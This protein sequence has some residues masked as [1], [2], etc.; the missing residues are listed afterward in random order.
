MSPLALPAFRNGC[1][2]R[3]TSTTAD[4]MVIGRPGA[5]A[6]TPTTSASKSGRL[7]GPED[8]RRAIASL[9]CS[10]T[11]ASCDGCP[12]RFLPRG[13][14][15]GRRDGRYGLRGRDLKA[16]LVCVPPFAWVGLLVIL[17]LLARG[18]D[19][20][21]EVVRELRLSEPVVLV[22]GLGETVGP[23]MLL[24]SVSPLKGYAKPTYAFGEMPVCAFGI[25]MF[26]EVGIVLAGAG[27][28]VHDLDF[29]TVHFDIGRGGAVGWV[30]GVGAADIGHF[31]DHV[32]KFGCSGSIALGPEGDADVLHAVSL[33]ESADLFEH[34]K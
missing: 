6:R 23:L 25:H 2:G 13:P 1:V 8:R 33:K 31:G 12:F 19:A 3:G 29:R 20:P 9:R 17:P 32:R 4:R 15:A 14:I 27:D 10:E 18:V 30:V 28:V 24:L 11:F 34:S 26:L 21:H 22:G 7:S 5:R 16:I